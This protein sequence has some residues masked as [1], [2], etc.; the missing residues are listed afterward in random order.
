VNLTNQINSSIENSSIYNN[1]RYGVNNSGENILYA[2]NNWWGS[3][4]GPAPF[5]SGNGINYRTCYDSVL[6][7]NYICQYYVDVSPWLG[8]AQTYGQ[9]IS[10]QRY[11]SDPVNT[12]SGNFAYNRTDLSIPTRSFPLQFSRAYNSA[13]P[14]AGVMGYGWTHSY[15]IRAVENTS[16]QSVTISF[17]DGH[18]ERFTWN[19]TSYVPPAGVFSTLARNSG[20]FRLTL[21]DQTVY[22]FDSLGRLATIND[23]NGNITTLGYTGTNLSQ[24]AVPDGAEHGAVVHRGEDRQAPGG[25]EH[26]RRQLQHEQVDVDQ[27]RP[28]VP[29]GLPG[30]PVGAGVEYGPQE[31]ARVAGVGRVPIE[32]VIG[33]CL[34]ALR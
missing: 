34:L 15:N 2:H 12:A 5:G 18:T 27:V 16:D 13:Y 6:K 10:Y 26:G 8:Q 25:H 1:G 7:K 29:D 31:G 21:K 9:K 30:R 14:E 32:Y 24:V 11:A 19:G 3:S 17:S 23:R 4:S 28:E 33:P 20:L 22:S